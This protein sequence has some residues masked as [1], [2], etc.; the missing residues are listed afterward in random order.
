MTGSVKFEKRKQCT[1]HFNA[2]CVNTTPYS[3]SATEAFIDT[4]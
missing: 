4:D 3:G 1:Y 2:T